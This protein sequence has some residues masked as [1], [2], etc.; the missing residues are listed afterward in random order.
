VLRLRE[1]GPELVW[2]PGLV[3]PLQALELVRVSVPLLQGPVLVR[4]FSPHQSQRRA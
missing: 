4:E 3:P 1:Q 2:E